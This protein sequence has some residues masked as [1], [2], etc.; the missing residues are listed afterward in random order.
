MSVIETALI[1]AQKASVH[2]SLKVARTPGKRLSLGDCIVR[3]LAKAG[4]LP[5]RFSLPDKDAIAL[6]RFLYDREA[7]WGGS[8]ALRPMVLGEGIGALNG[9]SKLGQPQI[10]ADAMLACERVLNAL[11]RK[12]LELL[13]WLEDAR[14][15]KGITLATLGQERYGLQEERQAYNQAC[16]ALRELAKS[17]EEH[18]PKARL[19]PW[20]GTRLRRAAPETEP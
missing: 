13:A 14:E 19:A 6:A 18:Y 8:G 20:S 16:G 3:D 5:F 9:R 1:T 7:Y 11:H 15:R 17:I 10:P 2:R 4:L 12:E